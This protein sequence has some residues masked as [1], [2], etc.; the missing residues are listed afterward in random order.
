MDNEKYMTSREAMTYLSVG[1]NTLKKFRRL[2]LPY[3]QVDRK[4]FYRRRDLDSFMEA[5]L[6]T[7]QDAGRLAAIK[8]APKERK[9]R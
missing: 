7:A 6:I 1:K 5:H 9:R 4:I 8:P 2:G 3:V